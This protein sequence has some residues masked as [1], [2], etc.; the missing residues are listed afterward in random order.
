LVAQSSR[1]RLVSPTRLSP[2]IVNPGFGLIGRLRLA[3]HALEKALAASLKQPLELA[4]H[5]EIDSS[6]RPHVR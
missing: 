3:W 2:A 1:A 5:V 4:G 6:S